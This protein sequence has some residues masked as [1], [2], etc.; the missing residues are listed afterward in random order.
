MTKDIRNYSGEGVHGRNLLFHDLR[1]GSNGRMR[2][3]CIRFVDSL[4][5]KLYE[6]LERDVTHEKDNGLPGSTGRQSRGKAR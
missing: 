1:V 3:G 5:V 6:T 4:P 2:A